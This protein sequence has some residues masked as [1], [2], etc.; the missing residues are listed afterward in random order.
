MPSFAYTSSGVGARIRPGMISA[1]FT[2]S[3]IV[4]RVAREYSPFDVPPSSDSR[5]SRINDLHGFCD[6][7]DWFAALR[8]FRGIDIRA[9]AADQRVVEFC[10]GIPNDQFRRNGRE[11]W[12]IKRAMKGRLPDSVLSNTK[13]GYQASDWFP[14]LGR[15]RAQ[16]AAELK[17]L[18]GNPEVSSIIDLQ[19]L[20]QVLD[21]WPEREPEVFSDEQRLL[22]WI[23]QALGTA[24]FIEGV[25]GV[26]YG[27]AVLNEVGTGG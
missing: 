26:N 25:T 1:Q 3:G 23:P 24:D 11:R 14:R 21:Q 8:A 6:M 12:L 2:R 22:M 20:I 13:K 15:E 17:R 19:R 5:L 16:I 18:T 9:P 7:A 27:A 10:I 4:E